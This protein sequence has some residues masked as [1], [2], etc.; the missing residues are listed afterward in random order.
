[1]LELFFRAAEVLLLLCFPVF[2]FLLGITELDM[3]V[4]VHS[5]ID[6]TVAHN[7]LQ[8]LRAN[9][10]QRHVRTVGMAADVRRDLR[11][12]V[13]EDFIVPFQLVLKV[14][15]PMHSHSW[16][17]GSIEKKKL[18]LA[19]DNGLDLRCLFYS[20]GGCSGRIRKLR[21]SLEASAFRKPSSY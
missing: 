6:R 15:L 21:P 12:L 1:M 20:L 7:V 8:G 10:G 16:L 17:A 4:D 14:M 3:S 11:K 18:C 13:L 5:Y 2:D 9:S 19:I